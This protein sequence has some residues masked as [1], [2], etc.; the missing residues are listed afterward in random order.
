MAPSPDGRK[1]VVILGGGFAGIGPR[2]LGDANVDIEL[3]SVDT[4]E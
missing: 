1:K 2:R 4:T 3:I